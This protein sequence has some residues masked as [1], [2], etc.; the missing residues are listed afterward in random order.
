MALHL[1]I[2]RFTATCRMDQG[3][4]DRETP[5]RA[6]HHVDRATYEKIG[7]FISRGA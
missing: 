6:G 4:P 2:F 3:P 7:S 1:P 5:S